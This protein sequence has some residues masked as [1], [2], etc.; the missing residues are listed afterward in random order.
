MDKACYPLMYK[1]WTPLFQGGSILNIDLAVLFVDSCGEASAGV[2][3]SGYSAGDGS[4]VS[5]SPR[6]QRQTWKSQLACSLM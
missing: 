1:T 3:S 5:G 2:S 6:K 4:D